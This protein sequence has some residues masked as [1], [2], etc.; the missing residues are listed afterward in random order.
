MS[1]SVSSECAFSQGGITI[2]KLQNCLKGDLVEALRGL[3]SGIKQDI[4]LQ[5]PMP[6]PMSEVE[7]TDDKNLDTDSFSLDE[8]FI[9]D[10]DEQA[11]YDSD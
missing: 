9:E 2:T 7:G 4:F 11:L 6:A 8:V 5:E 1:S 3:K 10:N